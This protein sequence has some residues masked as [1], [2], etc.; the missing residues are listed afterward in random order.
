MH[1]EVL[2]YHTSRNDKRIFWLS[3]RQ[4]FL[5]FRCEEQKLAQ[6]TSCTIMASVRN[7]KERKNKFKRGCW[8]ACK[9][10]LTGKKNTF[11]QR[12]SSKRVSS[13]R[14]M[15]RIRDAPLARGSMLLGWVLENGYLSSCGLLNH[16][17]LT[18]LK[19]PC[20]IL[21]GDVTE[22]GDDKRQP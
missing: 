11:Q 12:T 14:Q 17:S 13:M 22:R 21:S 19:W 9:H 1:L 5:C 7:S 15:G 2:E 3:V 16:S 4:P 10:C 20:V 6:S 8:K 18:C